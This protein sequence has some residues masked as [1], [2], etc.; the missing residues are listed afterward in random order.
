MSFHLERLREE[1]NYCRSRYKSLDEDAG[2]IIMSAHYDSRGSFGSIRHPGADD[3]GVYS[4]PTQPSR[5]AERLPA[6]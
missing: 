3:D 6:L 4:Q 1:T 5:L 2:T